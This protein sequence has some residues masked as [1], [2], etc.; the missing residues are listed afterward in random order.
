MEPP[1]CVPGQDGHCTVCA[2]EGEIGHVVEIRPDGLAVV[3]LPSGPVEIA[4]DLVP[5]AGV[6]DELIV[7]LGFAIARIKSRE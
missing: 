3:A 2:D 1:R 6:G 5:E 7:H 4:I